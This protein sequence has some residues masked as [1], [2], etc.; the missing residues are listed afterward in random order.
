MPKIRGIVSLYAQLPRLRLITSI[1]IEIK[2]PSKI[3][4]R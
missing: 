3:I 1:K 2:E 4:K